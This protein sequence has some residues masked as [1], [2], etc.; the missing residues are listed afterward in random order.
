M[1]ILEFIVCAAV[2]LYSTEVFSI[3]AVGVPR[4]LCLSVICNM[5]FYIVNLLD[6]LRHVSNNLGLFTP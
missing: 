6:S 1:V 4:S 2:K 3:S 5:K